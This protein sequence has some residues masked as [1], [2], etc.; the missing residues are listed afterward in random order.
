MDSRHRYF[1]AD[2]LANLAVIALIVGSPARASEV[3]TLPLFST[4]PSQVY[5]EAQK[6][7][8]PPD[9]DLYL[10][11][12]NISVHVDDDG[13]VSRTRRGVWRVL[14]EVGAK[15]LANWIEP[16]PAWREQKPVFQVRVI[17]SDKQAHRL[18]PATATVA[19]LP[20]VNKLYSDVQVLQAP[21]PAIGANSVVEFEV[22][23]GD[24]EIVMP[25]QR[26]DHIAFTIPGPLH[27]LAVEVQ[28]TKK[29]SAIARGFEKIDRKESREGE[30]QWVRFEAW[31]VRRTE[32]KQWLPPELP[33]GPEVILSTAASW[34][35]V[36]RWYQ[37]VTEPLLGADPSGD[38]STEPE[39]TQKIGVILA[40]VQKNVRYT[41]LELGLSAFV[42]H[43]PEETWKRGY[44]DCK[45]KAALLV[46]RLRK[47]GIPAK[48]ALLRPYPFPEVVSELPGLEAFNHVIVYVPGKQ[49]LWID[50]TSQ[51]TP[52][53]RLPLGD[54]GRNVLIVDR[55][56][57]ALV[58]T[59]EAAA[60]ENRL[61]EE[62]TVKIQPQGKADVDAVDTYAGAME[63][64]A[65]TLFA[66]IFAS[67]ESK[68]KLEGQLKSK[69][70]FDSLA[71]LD[72]SPATELGQSFQFKYSGHG[73]ELGT[74]QVE[75]ADVYLPFDRE[76]LGAL[77]Q[78]PAVDA[79]QDKAEKKATR[80]EDYYL[81][82]SFD[83]EGRYLVL[84]PSGF[85][86]KHL[87][88]LTKIDFG[89]V[90]LNFSTSVR[91]DNSVVVKYALTS[92]RRRYSVAEAEQI[93]AG[94][95]KLSTLP[96]LHLEFVD[97]VHE[98]LTSGKEKEA[99]ALARQR[100]TADPHSA[101][102][103]VRLAATLSALGMNLQAIEICRKATTLDPKSA[104][105]FAELA[106]LYT[107]DETGRPFRLGL[108]YF[109]AVEALQHSIELD[110]KDTRL[111]LK[112]ATLYE[113][114]DKGAHFYKHA[115]LAEAIAT[116]RKIE[117]DLP[118]LKS[119][120]ALPAA[121]FFNRQYSDVKKFYEND[122][123]DAP[124]S[125]RLAALAVTDG[126]EAAKS[127]LDQ[128]GEDASRKSQFT[129]AAGQLVFLHEYSPAGQLLREAMQE[130]N[131]SAQAEVAMLAKT[132]RREDARFSTEPP[133]AL[134]ERLI[135]ALLDPD[136]DENWKKLYVPE[137]RSLEVRGERNQLLATLRAWR[138]VAKVPVGW[139]TIADLA[140]SNADFVSE[141]SEETGYRVRIPD[142]SSNGALK[143][144]AWIVKRPDGY[145]VLGLGGDWATAGGE[146]LQ[147]AQK[148][149]LKSARQWLDWL[150]EEQTTPGGADPLAGLAFPK[151]WPVAKAGAVEM[152]NAAAS[153]AARGMHFET[154]LQALLEAG[155]NSTAGSYRDGI[156][157]AIIHCYFIHQKWA[158][159]LSEAKELHEEFPESDVGLNTLL[160]VLLNADD[161]SAA[162]KLVEDKLSK[163]PKS[164]INLRAQYRLSER[165]EDYLSAADAMRKVTHT[166][167]VTASDW[168]N[169]A[170]ISLLAN[171]TGVAA[172]EAANTANRL[173]QGR[174]AS[175]LHTLGC[176]KALQGDTAGARKALYQ[177]M[178]IGGSLDDAGRTL[179]GLIAEQLDLP[180]IARENFEKLKHPKFGVGGSSYALAQQRLAAMKP[181]TP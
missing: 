161:L 101:G 53:T 41:G 100:V 155:K 156:D 107:R 58:R 132:R 47:K 112:L 37:Q 90:K 4:D 142:S 113:H 159:A 15:Q 115:H 22:V 43:S 64:F 96:Y 177:Y 80:T 5:N 62:I 92:D 170:W 150:R 33:A 29:L 9:A 118:K 178:D 153:L 21:L 70:R 3:W 74:T 131:E 166:A 24:R 8:A 91:P 26:F 56:S 63:E 18:D 69:L 6:F 86:L 55:A 126:L 84:P 124:L 149:D 54:Q 130:E 85:R 162:R 174:N 109:D 52:A 127:V 123:N 167:K 137:W 75:T 77:N 13:R 66:S 119:E 116:L 28:A 157:L 12:L 134:T 171:D 17:T 146:A 172:L 82:A 39:R 95:K 32:L 117:D 78:L 152:I 154:G 60:S 93:A 111:A 140:V 67:P 98:L 105:A 89:P 2:F 25:G 30:T 61:D 31:D 128:T 110:P 97:Q 48:L 173:T 42:P 59:P 151:L 168:N 68:S 79:G 160:S 102:A 125:Y 38:E 11:E 72:S 163:D 1:P 36:A 129:S 175:Q 88:E 49:P 104:Q 71:S 23:S 179:L 114:D 76:I 147:A 51:Y 143:T 145:Q 40:D 35:D 181:N 46:S 10:I 169:L 135:Y 139:A 164:A 106:D 138:T 180:D 99:L 83:G 108:R 34:Q 50:P 16:W 176:V 19:G 122:T 141:G 148:G 65:R 14:T 81:P 120:G 133:I 165:A 87:P 103:L 94:I 45:D 158:N 27:H 20:G 44:G 121:L 57:M 73:W 136:D 7:K 144:I